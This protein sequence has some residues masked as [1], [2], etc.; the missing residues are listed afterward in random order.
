MTQIHATRRTVLRGGMI[1]G[2]AVYLAPLGSKAYAALFEKRLLTPA[3][4]NGADDTLRFRID[5][6]AKVT[7]E[8]IFARDIRARD[9]PH[10]PQQQGHALVLRVTQAD[11]IY[12]GFDL[13]AL[14]ADLMPD[15]IATAAD[16][17]RD[18][19]V[20][21]S[22]YGD[23]MLLPEGRTPAYLGQAVAIL[24]YHDF[25]RFRSAKAKLQFNDAAIHYGV[26]TGPL[27]RDPW[28]A[29]RLVREGGA[30]SVR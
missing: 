18:K 17:E 1:A 11:R 26:R 30:K 3:S 23:D 13:S 14:D 21:P 8:K 5:G 10:W 19:L 15:R 4:W 20:F 25:V 22:F 2:I 7:G 24:I 16:L 9:M 6:T 12:T 28:G 29:V 27:E